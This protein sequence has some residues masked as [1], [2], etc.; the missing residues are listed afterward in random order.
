MNVSSTTSTST[1]VKSIGLNVSATQPTTKS[2]TGLVF[3]MCALGTIFYCY[4]YYLRVAPSVM[5]TELKST[6]LLSDAA[7]GNLAA[8]FYYAYTPMQI[9]VG[10]LMDKFGPR[11]VLTFA[12]LC[13]VIGTYLFAST[14]N[15]AMAQLG[16]FLVGFGSA[17]A[18]VGVLKISNDW[19]PG[20]YFALM[21]GLTTTLGMVGAMSGELTMAYMVNAVGWQSTL[22]YSVILGIPLTVALWFILKDVKNSNSVKNTDTVKNL[23]S[24]NVKNL[25]NIENDSIANSKEIMERDT[26]EKTAPK[27]SQPKT[28]LLRGLF[29]EMICS[30][31]MWINGLI[32]CLTF[33]P[34]SAF[35][36]IWAVPFL[37][38]V[39]F[40][41]EE[42]AMGS[43][44]IFLG[45]AFGGP[46]FGII[47]EMIK[48]RRIPLI[49]GSFISAFFLFLAILFPST[50]KLWMYSLLFISSFFAGAEILVFAVSNDI[51]RNEVSATASA[52]TNMVVM[53]GGAVLPPLIGKLLDN[54]QQLSTITG[55]ASASSD[56]FSSALIV[57]PVALVLA[58][59]LS[60]WL[61]ETYREST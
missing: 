59:I 9:P 16:R 22:Y 48:S 4:E 38:S 6:F 19:L 17:F 26:I 54:S 30:P 37:V 21:A 42:A 46:C 32:G 61:K 52:F 18:Y 23:N 34:L 29:V 25:I 20:K 50:S 7:L 60:Y 33:L 1:A 15:I 55:A 57:I 47:S 24:E 8:C 11:R 14:Q 58:G 36:E 5:S 45:F 41:K 35:A 27:E 53:I 40:S 12:C 10:M 28:N 2:I 31:S 43:S 3:A 51:N 56:S 13:C 49:I 44:M 39:G